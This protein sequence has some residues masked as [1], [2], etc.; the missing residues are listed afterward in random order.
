MLRSAVLGLLL[1]LLAQSQL[2]P[3]FALVDRTPIRR[4][5]LAIIARADRIP[6]L[7]SPHQALI[8]SRECQA[9]LATLFQLLGGEAPTVDLL[10]GL[11]TSKLQNILSHQEREIRNT[12]S[13]NEF[14]FEG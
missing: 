12:Q 2:R 6:S 5:L 14:E 9:A 1:L 11:N 4:V 3:L 13:S 7:S 10:C 8:H